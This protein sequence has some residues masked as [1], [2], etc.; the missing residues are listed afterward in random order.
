VFAFILRRLLISLLL[1]VF[2]SII[3]YGIMTIAPGGPLSWTEMS[4]NV[5]QTQKEL[6]RQQLHFDQPWYKQYGYIMADLF[7]GK[8]R[9]FKDNRPVLLKIAER[10]PRTLLL[11]I[12]SILMAFG[13][14]IPLGI[15]AANNRGTW[16]DTSTAALAFL[17]IS[18]PSFWVSY[19]LCIWLVNYV[20][21]P[22][23]GTQT[24]GV[25]Y[26]NT[27]AVV[28]DQTWH[29][30][31][32]AFVLSLGT[33]AI[34]SRYMRASMIEALTEDYIRTARAKGLPQVV[35]LYKHALRNSLRPIITFVGFLLPALIGG[36][37]IV[38]TIFGYPGIGRLGYQSVMD[39]DYAVLMTLN[40]VAAALVLLG[41]LLAD[42]LYAVI[43]P[44]VRVH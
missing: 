21:V 34:W 7:T 6:M 4:P 13:L 8:L 32:P 5:S 24:L 43:D 9:S 12:V 10:L 18:M 1:L 3:S 16:K 31:A 19:L 33:I 35:V 14:A 11:N 41:N 2:I 38:E 42:V 36:S 22:L 15:F 40:T 28:L 26:S 44:R 25:A 37:V 27:L 29:V 30:F 39:R 23:L 17:L 20:Q